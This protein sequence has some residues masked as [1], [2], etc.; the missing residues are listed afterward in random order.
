MFRQEESFVVENKVLS[1]LVHLRLHC[2]FKH[3]LELYELYNVEV[4]VDL[5][6]TFFELVALS[7]FLDAAKAS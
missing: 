5:L 7:L 3:D 1:Q 4:L 2:D 6:D